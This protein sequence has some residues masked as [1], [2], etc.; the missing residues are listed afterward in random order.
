[1][2]TKIYLK[3]LH[4]WLGLT[5][6]FIASFSGIT[7]S[8]Y[9][10]QPEL[11]ALFEKDVLRIPNAD[12]VKYKDYLQT[13][14]NLESVHIDSLVAIRFPARERETIQVDFISGDSY[15][16]HPSSGKYLGKNPFTVTFFKTLLQLHRNLCIGSPGKYIIGT[17]SLLF[18]FLILISGLYLWRNIYKKRWKKGFSFKR[19]TNSK[20]F[21]FN[22]HRLIGIYGL[23]P[24]FII[25]ITG[26][27][28]TYYSSYEQILNTIPNFKRKSNT[29]LRLPEIGTPF[30]FDKTVLDLYPHYKII[31]IKY[32]INNKSTYRFRFTNLSAIQSGL[33]KPIDIFTTHNRVITKIN[34]YKAFS[35][36]KKIAAQ[37]YPIHI[38][39][40]FGF[41]NRIV[42]FLVGLLPII[43]FITGLRFF[44]FRKKLL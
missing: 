10:W 34:S 17:A 18:G 31:T 25:A 4:L 23:L 7:G 2:K 40:S 6:G 5:V 35:K 26:S 36:T 11:S 27:Y 39:E 32:P 29:S 15:Y 37:M 33:R 30:N 3:Q 41:L 20:V 13:A 1:M 9:V 21:N 14:K 44:L 22:L 42:V 43:L 16:Y 8:L 24:L 38:G 12:G 28:F 19:N